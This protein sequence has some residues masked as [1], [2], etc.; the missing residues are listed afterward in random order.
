NHLDELRSGSY[1]N[2]D[3]SAIIRGSSQLKRAG[4]K[5]LD[6]RTHSRRKAETCN[7]DLVLLK[8]RFEKNSSVLKRNMN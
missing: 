4:S 1:D 6:F 3:H 8:S 7:L 2:M 5:G